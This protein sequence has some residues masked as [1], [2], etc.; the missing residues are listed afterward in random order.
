[1][2]KSWINPLDSKGKP[3]YR[4]ELTWQTHKIKWEHVGDVEYQDNVVNTGIKLTKLSP[5]HILLSPWS[6]MRENLATD[7][8]DVA[9]IGGTAH[10]Q[11]HGRQEAPS[12]MTRDA[13][14]TQ[15][16]LYFMYLHTTYAYV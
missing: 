2:Y 10:S 15:S 6:K 5:E 13:R 9:V 11:L 12:G 1:M 7:V 16:C 3:R 14:S 8:F 4:R